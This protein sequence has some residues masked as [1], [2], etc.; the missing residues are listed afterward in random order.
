[1][2]HVCEMSDAAFVPFLLLFSLLVIIR[3]HPAC[4]V[5]LPWFRFRLFSCSSSSSLLLLLAL[6]LVPSSCFVFSTF[7]SVS[8]VHFPCRTWKNVLAC[9][10]SPEIP[11]LHPSHEGAVRR[12]R[13]QMVLVTLF[14][15][16]HG[17]P[18]QIP[19]L[20]RWF[21]SMQ[22]TLRAELLSLGETVSLKERGSA[23]RVD[24]AQCLPF[25]LR[26]ERVFWPRDHLFRECCVCE[27]WRLIP[28]SVQG[29]ILAWR[30]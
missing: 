27:H 17:S 21:R 1:M 25:L 6:A 19:K 7:A 18:T 2:P 26:C 9:T 30:R 16:I 22:L 12:I 24:P 13:K 8:S 14:V 10:F 29:R 3:N 28:L 20:S 15:T 23:R 11:T 5:S 4:P